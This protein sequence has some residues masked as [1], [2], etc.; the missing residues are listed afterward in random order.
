MNNKL[1]VVFLL[2]IYWIANHFIGAL[3]VYNIKDNPLTDFSKFFNIAYV[4]LEFFDQFI[5]VFL[6]MK[7]ADFGD[8]SLY[9]NRIKLLLS[10]SLIHLLVIT[11]MNT[12]NPTNRM[13]SFEVWMISS[14]RALVISIVLVAIGSILFFFVKPKH[15]K[16]IN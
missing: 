8:F 5:I 6:I 11:I 7:Y 15:S 4:F 16:P 10:V 12:L 1:L 9:K 14:I 3:Y 13:I 2:V